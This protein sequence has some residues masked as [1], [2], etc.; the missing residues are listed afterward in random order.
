MSGWYYKNGYSTKTGSLK[1]VLRQS[2]N[3]ERENQHL[4]HTEIQAVNR[5]TVLSR[6]S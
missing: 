1:L 2:E 5:E 3:L 4:L 6:V